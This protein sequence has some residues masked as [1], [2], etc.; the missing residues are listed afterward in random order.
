MF[1]AHLN[2]SLA[3]FATGL[4]TFSTIYFAIQI[5]PIAQQSR[6]FHRC[7]Q[8]LKADPDRQL[9]SNWKQVQ[10]CNGGK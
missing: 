6:L 3:I 7:V 10:I 5:E 9:Q 8:E 1:R 4:A 2:P